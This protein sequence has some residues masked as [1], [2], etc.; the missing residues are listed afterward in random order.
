MCKQC[1]EIKYLYEKITIFKYIRN[2]AFN[3]DINNKVKTDE[4]YN[5]EIKKQL[6]QILELINKKKKIPILQLY[7]KFNYK[8]KEELTEKEKDKIGINTN[9]GEKTDSWSNHFYEIFKVGSI[10][11]FINE[12]LK[13]Y[14]KKVFFG[15]FI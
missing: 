11:K 8:N 4:Q 3:K 7:E 14:E 5:L 15:F 1:D 6:E 10:S 12:S 9:F 13:F 2:L